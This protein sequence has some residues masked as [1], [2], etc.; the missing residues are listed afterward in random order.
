[1]YKIPKSDTLND[2][3]AKLAK[4]AEQEAYEYY[5]L[6]FSVFAL[7]KSCEIIGMTKEMIFRGVDVELKGEVS[8]FELSNF[9]KEVMRKDY[10]TQVWIHNLSALL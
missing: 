8:W 10:F 7:V 9:L 5:S 1:M 6:N 3:R 4:F 2:I